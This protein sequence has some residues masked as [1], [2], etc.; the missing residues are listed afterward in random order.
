MR[1]QASGSMEEHT[2]LVAEAERAEG[3]ALTAACEQLQ[4][5]LSAVRPPTEALRSACAAIY[6]SKLCQ[7]GCK[8]RVLA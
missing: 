8:G 4:A 6:L 1:W 2:A 3:G 7:P 5:L